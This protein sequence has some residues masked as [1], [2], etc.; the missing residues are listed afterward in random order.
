MNQPSNDQH[1]DA[2]EAL[3]RSVEESVA[4]WRNR[5]VEA[6]HDLHDHPELAFEETRSA[7]R[8]AGLLASAGF[9]TRV[10]AYGLDT[11]VEAVFGTGSLTVTVCAEYDAL[12]GI[13]HG[14]GHNIIATAGV[15]AAIALA[16]VADELDLRIKLLGTPA[17]EVGGGKALMLEAGA[18]E[19]ATVSLMVHPG[20]SMSVR[21]SE[22]LSQ[23]RDRF[24]VTFH[25]HAAH[26][27]AAPEAGINAGDAATLLQVAL[28]LLRQQLPDR[29]RL[30]A[31]TLNA[32]DVSNVI[33]AT[34]TLE[35]EVRS[36]D[37][38][39]Q[40]RLKER[41]LACVEGAAIAT[42]C[43]FEV[44]P[45]DPVYEPLVQHPFLADRY[46]A[47][48]ERAGREIQSMPFGGTGGS[49]DMGNVS[50]VVPSIHPAIAVIGAK[51]M[52]HTAEFAAETDTPAAD[53]AILVA[54]VAMASAIIDLATDP[55]A[56]AD[57][58]ADQRARPV[59][60]TRKPAHP[61]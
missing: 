55:E 56:R 13:G 47:A 42:G 20:P 26:A 5:L 4:A 60:A 29:I 2:R 27:A 43:T 18:W 50:Q 41:Y 25:G 53:E 49:T 45:V 51:G 3:Y 32:G 44:T 15:G 6:S 57:V 46:D 40:H 11:A 24:R 39:Q 8:V 34:A 14:C 52:A 33:P 48:I 31:V 28:G 10:G 58:L 23:G 38:D 54:A 12:P 7:E 30:S 17:E 22:L 37:A 19:D 36:I 16:G 1:P 61:A 35:G 9:T 59:G 21:T